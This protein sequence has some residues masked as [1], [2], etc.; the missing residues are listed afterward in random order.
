MIPSRM[1]SALLRLLI[2]LIALM[3]LHGTNGWPIDRQVP[4]LRANLELT[5]RA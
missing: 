3:R 5:C 1:D 2:V 4:L